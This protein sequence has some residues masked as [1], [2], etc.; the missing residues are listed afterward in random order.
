MGDV[1]GNRHC[2]LSPVCYRELDV[3]PDGAACTASCCLSS[4]RE[5]CSMGPCTLICAFPGRL[6]LPDLLT[7]ETVLLGGGWPEH[8]TALG[9]AEASS[10]GEAEVLLDCSESTCLGPSSLLQGRARPGYSCCLLLSQ[11]LFAE[12]LCSPS[13]CAACS[14]PLPPTSP[15]RLKENTAEL[16]FALVSGR[17]FLR[18]QHG[19]KKKA[20]ALNH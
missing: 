9:G 19:G 4:S 1:H 16:W 2:S 8:S 3:V 20:G 5:P 10:P 12:P 17:P 6:L 15:A 7:L 13:L 14:G 18:P 11:F